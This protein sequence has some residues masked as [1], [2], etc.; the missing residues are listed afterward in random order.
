MMEHCIG[1]IVTW[2]IRHDAVEDT[3]RELYEYAVYSLIITLSPLL[4]IM[5]IGS[6]MGMLKESVLLI[7]P[8]MIIR[9]FS[10]G[11]HAKYGR[12]CFIGSCVVLFLCVV[13]VSH[14]TCNVILN[15]IV[16]GAVTGLCI[17]SPIDS[18]NRRL[19]DEEKRRYK[20]VT[21][22]TA[23]TFAV[24]YILLNMAKSDTYAVCIAVG[25]MLPAGLQVPAILQK[26]IG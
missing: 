6:F 24:L 16:L 5:I 8:F 19:S 7:L 10:G 9:K 3:D 15:V 13:L 20:K 2:L 25:L 1:S 18:D 4:I 22:A 11:F 21:C 12:T 23:V 26:Y 17:W 14:I